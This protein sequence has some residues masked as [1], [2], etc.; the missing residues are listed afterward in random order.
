M[1]RVGPIHEFAETA[2]LTPKERDET[3]G[4]G[5]FGFRTEKSLHAPAEIRAA[6]RAEAMASRQLPV[7]AQR[8]HYWRRAS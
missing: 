8:A 1:I 7:V 5:G 6:P 2:A 3:R 4:A